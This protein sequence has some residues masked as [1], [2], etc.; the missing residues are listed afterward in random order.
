MR[1]A[2]KCIVKLF[3]LLPS[4]FW[5]ITHY[6]QFKKNL[7]RQFDIHNLKIFRL[8]DWHLGNFYFTATRN[9]Q[10]IFIKTDFSM[11]LLV[12]EAIS[13]RLM[14]QHPVLQRHMTRMICFHE[15][16]IAYEFVSQMNLHEL[17]HLPLDITVLENINSQLSE[18]LDALY[19]LGIVHRDLRLHNLL[20]GNDYQLKLID[21]YFAISSNPQYGF[22]ELSSAYRL[23]TLI[24]RKLGHTKTPME[25]DDAY[26]LSQSIQLINKKHRLDCMIDSITPRIDRLTFD[27]EHHY[28]SLDSH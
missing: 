12:N 26:C 3:F 27:M 22:V 18:I 4:V 14:Q 16:W 13:N 28:K 9:H 8:L 6:V 5:L 21:F 7:A 19:A 11:G 2:K 17:L 1:F 25:W 20:I 10:R 15:T 23:K 24:L